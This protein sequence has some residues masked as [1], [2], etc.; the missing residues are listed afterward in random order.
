MARWLSMSTQ[1]LSDPKIEA[2]GERHGPGGP[3]IIFALMAR[4]KVAADAGRVTCSFRTL[5]HESFTDREEVRRVIESAAEVSLIT[6]EDLT[7]A[8][9]TVHFPAFRRWQEAGRKAKERESENPAPEANV[10]RRP[11]VSGPVPTD[12]QTDKETEKEKNAPGGA[13]KSAREKPDPDVLPDG[14]PP[15]LAAAVKASLLPLQRTAQFKGAKPVT[16]L[17]VARAIE[18]RPDRDHVK[19][20]SEVEHWCCYGKGENKPAKDI[21]ARFRTFLDN[22]DAV[23]TRKP[24]PRVMPS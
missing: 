2:L 9:A 10:R 7:E 12:R 19:V 17:A 23:A 16:V 22:S 18:T 20:A 3:L 4:A 14:F 15:H 6:V 1:F 8:E 13:R 24:P 21:V 5:A 11:E